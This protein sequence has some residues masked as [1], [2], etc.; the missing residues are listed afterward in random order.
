MAGITTKEFLSMINQGQPTGSSVNDLIKQKPEK[1]DSKLVDLI[2]MFKG[3][4]DNIEDLKTLQESEDTGQIIQENVLL[5]Q[6]FEILT[7]IEG[8]LDKLTDPN[9]KMNKDE[10]ENLRQL[11]SLE[12]AQ[13]K[14]IQMSRKTNEHPL[15]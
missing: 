13:I 6:Y 7:D 14:E 2:E 4:K 5:N 12:N 10:A 8:L 15:I 11:V 3:M 9:Y 1:L